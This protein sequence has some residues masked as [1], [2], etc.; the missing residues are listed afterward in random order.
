MFEKRLASSET[1]LAYSQTVLFSVTILSHLRV[2]PHFA[3]K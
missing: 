1:A 3:I 2:M